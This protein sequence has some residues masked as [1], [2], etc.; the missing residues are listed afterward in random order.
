MQNNRFNM[1]HNYVG[2]QENCNKIT[3][4]F[5]KSKITL[6][7]ANR[8]LPT[9]QMQII[10]VCMWDT[11]VAM[12][13]SYINFNLVMLTRSCF[14]S[15]CSIVI[16]TCEI[17]ISTSI[18]LT[19]KSCN[20]RKCNQ[21]IIKTSSIHKIWNIAKIRLPTFQIKIIYHVDILDKFVEIQLISV[22][23]QLIKVDMHL[24]DVDMWINY[25]NMNLIFLFKQIMIPISSFFLP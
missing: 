9:C 3:I 17:R 4:I 21:R 6:N 23:I 16:L 10:Y 11:F 8:W 15:T 1:Q 18:F 24:I 5:K 13:L 2:M 25:I 22:D 7:I 12:Q 14:M 20:P 19:I